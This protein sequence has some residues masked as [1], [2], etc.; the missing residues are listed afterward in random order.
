MQTF[1]KSRSVASGALPNRT[2]RLP[3]RYIAIACQMPRRLQRR[4]GASDA[5]SR[6]FC[7]HSDDEDV[8][9]QPEI[10]RTSLL[11]SGT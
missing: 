2:D 9:S 7:A 3:E 6:K 11:Q 8:V 5:P 10:D 4:S 1:K